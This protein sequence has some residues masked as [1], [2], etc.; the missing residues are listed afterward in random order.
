MCPIRDLYRLVKVEEIM[1]SGVLENGVART[2][3][4]P[5]KKGEHRLR[6][7]YRKSIEM[8]SFSPESEPIHRA[9]HRLRKLAHPIHQR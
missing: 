4:I 7:Y 3:G 1:R 9:A 6:N 5:V 8:V 2:T